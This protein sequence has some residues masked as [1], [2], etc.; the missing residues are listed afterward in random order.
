MPDEFPDF[1][2]PDGKPQEVDDFFGEPPSLRLPPST[3]RPAPV[4]L[5]SMRDFK[6]L[7]VD[8]PR[9][10]IPDKVNGA[11]RYGIDFKVPG[12]VQAL[13]TTGPRIGS[14]PAKSTIRPRARCQAC[15][16]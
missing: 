14:V 10:D 2:P 1:L 12:M 11:A 6:L 9:V 16:T 13:V 4:Q 15:S 3:T 5:K 8:A 7:G